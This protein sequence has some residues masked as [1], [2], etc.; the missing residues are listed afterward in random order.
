[1]TDAELPEVYCE[2]LRKARKPHRCCECRGFIL[3]GESY[4]LANGIWN[5]GPLTFKTCLPC[6]ALRKEI[7]ATLERYEVLAFE[8]LG[9]FIC[10]SGRADWGGRWEAIK[11][12]AKP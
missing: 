6:V 11:R 8:A 12:K 4:Q 1:M 5:D 7:A 9:E 3:T 2:T 10:D